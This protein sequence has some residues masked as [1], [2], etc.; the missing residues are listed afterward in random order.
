MDD[1]MMVPIR[2]KVK[3]ECVWT[4]QQRNHQIKK[5]ANDE[6]M[7]V[8]NKSVRC[9]HEIDLPA[10]SAIVIH[11]PAL[12][13]WFEL[14]I[15]LFPNIYVWQPF[16]CF[17]C[18]PFGYHR[19]CATDSL[20]LCCFRC[21]PFGSSSLRLWPIAILLLSLSVIRISSSHSLHH[22]L[23]AILLLYHF[24]RCWKWKV[25]SQ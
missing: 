12:F 17:R 24:H 14:L 13:Y 1:T 8:N 22:W 9:A 15:F 25:C 16:S 5:C 4:R 20:Q 6:S 19:H 11:V 3:I 2:V 10:L 7:K 21:R 18:R 23:I